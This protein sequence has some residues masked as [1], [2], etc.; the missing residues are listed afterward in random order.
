MTF[1]LAS[2]GEVMASEPPVTIINLTPI[3]ADC[4]VCGDLSHRMGIPVYEDLI[5]PNH[6]D[7]EWGGVPA[8]REC[9]E[10]QGL[11]REPTA[12]AD[13]RRLRGLDRTKGGHRES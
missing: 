2:K 5:L 11:L 12:L 6:H 8:C 3:L 7:G 9:F 10:L 13:F 4:W 1:V